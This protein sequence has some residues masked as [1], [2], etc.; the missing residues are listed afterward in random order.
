MIDRFNTHLIFYLI[1]FDFITNNKKGWI[2]EQR[3]LL[4]GLQCSFPLAYSSSRDSLISCRDDDDDLMKSCG[5]RYR[6]KK[7]YL[8]YFSI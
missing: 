4:C 3:E 8:N 5:D 7:K 1:F 6:S 2:F